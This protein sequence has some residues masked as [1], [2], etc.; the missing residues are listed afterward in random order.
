[1][2]MGYGDEMKIRINLYILLGILFFYLVD[3]MKIYGMLMLFV[4]F[5]ELGHMIVGMCFRLKVDYMEIMPFGFSIRFQEKEY[6]IDGKKKANI[7]KILVALAGPLVNIL[8]MIVMIMIQIEQVELIYAN[9]LIGMFNLLPIYP[10]DGGRML[11][12]IMDMK[13]DYQRKRKY[14]ERVSKITMVMLT[15]IASILLFYYK[16]ILI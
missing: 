12:A 9:L 6:K 1:M 13:L 8:C 5:H 14:L 16:N 3:E 11:E 10:L 15:G 4:F 2:E 7:R